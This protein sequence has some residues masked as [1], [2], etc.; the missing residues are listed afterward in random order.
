[1]T[2][3]PD[4]TNPP[5][6]DRSYLLVGH[7]LLRPSGGMSAN[8]RNYRA[9]SVLKVQFVVPVQPDRHKNIQHTVGYTELAPDRFKGSRSERQGLSLSVMLERDWRLPSIAFRRFRRF[10]RFT[11]AASRLRNGRAVQRCREKD[12]DRGRGYRSEFSATG[13]KPPAV[14]VS[15][16]VRTLVVVRHFPAP[17]YLNGRGTFLESMPCEVVKPVIGNPHMGVNGRATRRPAKVYP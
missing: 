3:F 7:S 13:E 17:T 16:H 1:M 2:N 5:H 9:P 14:L 6:D 10:R 8:C 15:A 12:S 4:T 11:R